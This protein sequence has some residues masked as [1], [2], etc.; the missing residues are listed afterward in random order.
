MSI[1]LAWL[2]GI[3]EGEGSFF[4]AKQLRNKT[5]APQ[6]R[7]TI[8]LTNTDPMIINKAYSIFKGFGV[9]LHIQEF[10][11]KKGSTKPV[12]EMTTAQQDKVQKVCSELIPFM[13]GEKKAKAEML[14]RFVTKRLE[15]R[16]SNKKAGYDEED[17]VTYTQFYPNPLSSETLRETPAGED[18]VQP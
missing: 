18:K 12:Y 4:I 16:I 8:S 1:E 6:L 13:F 5:P 11:N 7:G 17:W 2:A 15:K 10:T 14:L 3:M 9:E